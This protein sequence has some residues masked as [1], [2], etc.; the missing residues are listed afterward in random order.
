MRG[1]LFFPD[2]IVTWSFQLLFEENIYAEK[3]EYKEDSKFFH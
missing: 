2:L 3:N 1:L